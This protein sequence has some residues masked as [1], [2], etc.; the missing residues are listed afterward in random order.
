MAIANN[1][2]KGREIVVR[3]GAQTYGGRKSF[4]L[5]QTSDILDVT[6]SSDNDWRKIKQGAK[7]WTIPLDGVFVEGSTKITGCPTFKVAADGGTL[8]ALSGVKNI[9]LAMSS[10]LVS[11]ENCSSAS[12]KKYLAGQRDLVLTVNYDYLDPAGTGGIS[13]QAQHA[14]IM[15]AYEGGT[16][17][18]FKLEPSGT[19]SFTGEGIV[20]DLRMTGEN[21]GIITMSATIQ[22]NGAIT[23]TG[24][25]DAGIEEVLDAL[26]DTTQTA[27]AVLMTDNEGSNWT[28]SSWISD[29]TV[30]F[31]YGAESKMSCTLT[32]DGA[33]ARDTV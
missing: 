3:F 26:L 16:I 24:T 6:D 23:R 2:Q 7:S 33:L 22:V 29:A 11:I 4:T 9:S 12:W 20:S 17:L 14:A 5:N 19:C 27:K 21:N 8:T 13:Q 10:Q 28:G 25:L 31:T 1:F 18:D 15:V 32:G 30:E